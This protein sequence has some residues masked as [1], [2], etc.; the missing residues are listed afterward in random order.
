LG[1]GREE[2]ER[3]EVKEK[4]EGRQAVAAEGEREEGEKE[5]GR[6]EGR[7][8]GRDRGREGGR[9]RTERP[10]R[11]IIMILRG[12]NYCYVLFTFERGKRRVS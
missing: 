9:R 7:G 5:G 3:R 11:L 12:F 8:E 4:I 2:G 6:G 1:G 10:K